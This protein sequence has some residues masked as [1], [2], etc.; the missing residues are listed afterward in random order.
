MIPYDYLAADAGFTNL[1]PVTEE[2]ALNA[3]CAGLRTQREPVRDV[4]QALAEAAEWFRGNIGESA[5]IAAARTS[6]E[7][8]YALRAC[9]ALAA[10]GVIPRDLRCGRA[11]LAAVIEAMRSSGLIPPDAPDPIAAAVDYSYLG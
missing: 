10:D 6:V 5:A 1:G 4:L 3:A 7:P 2:F 8:R 9:E 11:A